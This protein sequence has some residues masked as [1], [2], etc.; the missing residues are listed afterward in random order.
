MLKKM[1]EL[2]CLQ[3]ENG[4]NNLLKLKNDSIERFK[5]NDRRKKADRDFYEHKENKFHGLRDVRN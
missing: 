2:T 3:I 5:K 1:K 4:K